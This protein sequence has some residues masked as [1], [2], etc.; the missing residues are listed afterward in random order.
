MF[1]RWPVLLSG[2]HVASRPGGALR[3]HA[4]RLVPLRTRKFRSSLCLFVLRISA[5][6]SE[7]PDEFPIKRLCEKVELSPEIWTVANI[8]ASLSF[9]LFFFSPWQ[10][11]SRRGKVFGKVNCKNIKQDCPNLDC[12]DPVLLP[13]H[14]CKT[15]LRSKNPRM[16][17]SPSHTCG[18]SSVNPVVKIRSWG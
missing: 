9:F 14:C 4:L 12:D 3:R 11:K 1:V 10:Q 2:G 5:I 15:C 16:Q 8:S 18:P 17:T 6:T 7:T 13:G